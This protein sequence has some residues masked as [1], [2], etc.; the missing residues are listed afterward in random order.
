MR[1]KRVHRM[2]LNPQLQ[3]PDGKADRLTI[4][5]SVTFPVAASDEVQV[6]GAIDD[7]AVLHW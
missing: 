1:C 7:A 6:E 3:P 4:L 2:G 5:F